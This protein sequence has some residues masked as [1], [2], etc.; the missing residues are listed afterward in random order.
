MSKICHKKWHFTKKVFFYKSRGV[1]GTLTK[2]AT[3]SGI[4]PKKWHKMKKVAHKEHG[5]NFQQKVAFKKK[6][7]LRKQGAW[8]NAWAK[9]AT[10]SGILPKKKI[11][12]KKIAYK[13]LGRNLPQ[14]VAFFQK[15]ANRKQ[16]TWKNIRAKIAIKSGILPI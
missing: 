12:K 2:L 1:I 16:V 15:I 9:F 11:F 13:D 8:K 6:I 7:A 5:P 3:K 4:S 14:K 10:K